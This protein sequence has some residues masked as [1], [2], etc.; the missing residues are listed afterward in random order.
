MLKMIQN[1]MLSGMTI[2]PQLTVEIVTKDTQFKM[3]VM[4]VDGIGIGGVI[5]SVSKDS[6]ETDGAKLTDKARG[7]PWANVQLITITR[8]NE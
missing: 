4:S 3:R 5:E 7:V 2:Q 6:T 1:H 8:E